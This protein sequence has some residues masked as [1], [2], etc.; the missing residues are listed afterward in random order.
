MFLSVFFLSN[1]KNQIFITASSIAVAF[2]LGFKK[3]GHTYFTI[4][5]S[6]LYKKKSHYFTSIS[7]I[8]IQHHIADED[9]IYVERL[10]VSITENLFERPK[11]RLNLL[12]LCVCVL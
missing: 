3:G 10:E 7:D 1:V 8:I 12:W 2:F 9:D 5:Y 11:L 6:F 4:L